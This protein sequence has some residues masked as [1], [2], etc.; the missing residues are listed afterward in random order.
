[1][2]TWKAESNSIN[3]GQG[4]QI[5]SPSTSILSNAAAKLSLASSVIVEIQ[6]NV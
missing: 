1:M 2:N 5:N 3:S 4:T 6:F